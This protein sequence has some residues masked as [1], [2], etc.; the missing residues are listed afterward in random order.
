MSYAFLTSLTNATNLIEG[1]AGSWLYWWFSQPGMK[2]FLN[3]FQNS[4]LDIAGIADQR[5]L[6][7]Q[8]FVYISLFFNLLSVPF[9][10]LLKRALERHNIEI[11][12]LKES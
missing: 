3:A 1:L 7:L 10:Y 5:T 6:I 11:S 4:L 2:P 12:D 8:L 9:I